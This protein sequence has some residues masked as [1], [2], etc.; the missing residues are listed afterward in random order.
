MFK[1][2]FG[3]LRA[4]LLKY[5][6]DINHLTLDFNNE[7]GLSIWTSM[8]DKTSEEVLKICDKI[9]EDMDDLLDSEFRR[10]LCIIVI[11]GKE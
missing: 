3:I 10:C 7:G 9:D 11:G 2:Q 4:I 8:E 1:I 6:I 5:H